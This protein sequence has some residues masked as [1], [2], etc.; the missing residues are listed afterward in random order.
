MHQFFIDFKKAYG[1]VRMEV[2]YNILPECGFPMKLVRLI[3]ICLNE[4]R[5]SSDMF[6]VKNG[7][8]QVLDHHWFS[9]LFLECTSR[10]VQV[11]QDG[12]KLIY[13]VEAYILLRRTQKL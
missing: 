6:P 4:T 5:S 13:W 8:K 9:T 10:R 1:S 3:K 7:F 2:L 11:N 12:L